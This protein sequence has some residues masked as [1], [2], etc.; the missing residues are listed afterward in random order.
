MGTVVIVAP[1]ALTGLAADVGFVHF[2]NPMQKI[3]LLGR[4]PARILLHHVPCG[5]L[6]QVD[7][8]G[9]LVTGQAL[10]GVED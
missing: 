7:I 8:A 9:E 10:L 3:G 6:I 5:L 2:D 1:V 4:Q